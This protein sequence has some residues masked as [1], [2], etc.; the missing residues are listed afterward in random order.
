MIAD[1][2]VSVNLNLYHYN[3]KQQQG[4][5]LQESERKRRMSASFFEFCYR[6]KA[7]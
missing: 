6:V 3:K 1:E 4:R 5:V 7:S 2:A